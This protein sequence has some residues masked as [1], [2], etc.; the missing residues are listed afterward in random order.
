MLL[1]FASS[2][3]KVLLELIVEL[4][5]VLFVYLHG[6]EGELPTVDECGLV[7]VVG[8]VVESQSPLLQPFLHQCLQRYQIS[9]ITCF[10]SNAVQR[11]KIPWNFRS[12][13]LLTVL[14]LLFLFVLKLVAIPYKFEYVH[15][16]TIVLQE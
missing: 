1:C 16:L 11:F 6:R 14:W 4:V 15:K 8:E 13:S 7:F 5:K 9:E 2:L 3:E 10:P 12:F